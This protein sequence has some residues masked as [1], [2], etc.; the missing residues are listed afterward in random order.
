MSGLFCSSNSTSPIT[1][2][3]KIAANVAGILIASNN[4]ASVATLLPAVQ[5]I[6]AKVEGGGDNAAMNVLI[7]QGINELVSTYTTNPQ[8]KLEADIVV[9]ALGLNVPGAVPTLSNS[10]I[11]EL[12]NSF[13]SGLQAGTTKAS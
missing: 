8:I 2:V 13:I 9:A 11:T 6:L 5:A 4:Q 7:S 10:D 12:I 3:V 1:S